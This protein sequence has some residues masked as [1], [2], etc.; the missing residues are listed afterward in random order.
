[1][2]QRI[3]TVYLLIVAALTVAMLFMPLAVIQ[4]ANDFFM[5]DASGLN[6]MTTPSELITPMWALMAL[7][8]I[9]TLIAFVAIFLFKKR[10]L[11]IRLC[12]FNS[13]LLIGFYGLLAFYVWKIAG[14]SD[15]FHFSPRIALGFPL[16]S[17]I[18]NYLAIRNI[19]ADEALVRSLERLR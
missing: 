14:Q 1:M 11:Q 7:A 6:T 8:S 2:I 10:V 19:G 18:L 13:L 3:Q 5:L 16:V 12:I 15:I 17:L 9:I 4:S